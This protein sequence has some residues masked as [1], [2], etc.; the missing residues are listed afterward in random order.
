MRKEFSDKF[1]RL[2]DL[3]KINA[4]HWLPSTGKSGGILCGIKK[5]RFDIIKVEEKEFAIV[6]EVQ[7]KFPR[8]NVRLVMIYG[9]AQDD[10]KN[11]FLSELAGIGANNKIPTLIGGD[12]NILRYS[13]EKNKTFTGNRFT[14]LFNWI[15]NTY[16]LRD[17]P[18][19]GG[20]FT[21]SNNHSPNSGKIGQS[22]YKS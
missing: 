1:F 15:I 11:I 18:L 14:N 16:E 10:K 13:F 22:A 19:N 9:P 17:L 3:F 5:E 2:I 7:D 8:I 20:L 4:W 12:F 6:A 21:W